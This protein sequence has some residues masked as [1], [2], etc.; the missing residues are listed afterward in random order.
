MYAQVAAR[1]KEIG[2][3]RALGYPRRS[4]LGAFLVEAAFLG[5][6]AGIAGAV[7]ALPL[8]GITTGTTNFVTFS[9][10]TFSL[11]TTPGILMQG[12]LLAIATGMIGGLVPAW[13]AARRPIAAL[14]RE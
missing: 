12:V 2:T 7:L 6:I 3:L 8:N 1:S 10:I 4:I 14:L 11:R 13:S 5:L 9:E